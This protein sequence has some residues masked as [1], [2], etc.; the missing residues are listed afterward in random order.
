MENTKIIAVAGK[1]GVG[2]TS[3]SA[4]IVKLL[5][6]A[7]PDKKILAI[8]ADPAVGL[9]TALGIDV[10]MTI[11]DIR[12]EIV[13]TVEGGDTKTAIELLGDARYKI[14]D[15]LVET[16][17][18]AFIAVGRPETAG[19][20]CKINS[21]LKEVISL[22][23]GEFD[24]VV[25]DGEAGI[26]QINRRVM[27]KVTHLILITDPSKK[28]CQ[29][30]NTIKGVAD[31]LVMYEK[32]GAVVNRIPDESV[33]PY[34]D[35]NGIPVLSAIMNDSNLAVFDMQGK[36]VFNL[37]DDTNIVSGVQKAL[38]NMEIL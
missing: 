1:G 4:T 30:I 34:I 11:D 17:G 37:P 7:Y 26:E 18:Y 29:V 13:A 10:K 22:L 20:Y 38:K 8:D 6:K 14:F 23:A 15:A 5:V 16:D 27:E 3:I 25:I 9:S 21:Y 28:G 35:T 36:N 31:D 2:K 32:I 12:K 24:Y 19:C 33:L